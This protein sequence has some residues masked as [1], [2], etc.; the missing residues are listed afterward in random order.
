MM[1]SWALNITHFH[2]NHMQIQKHLQSI[3]QSLKNLSK[4]RLEVYE[5]VA[6]WRQNKLRYPHNYVFRYFTVSVMK[7]FFSEIHLFGVKKHKNRTG[8]MK[9][10]PQS[11]IHLGLFVISGG[12][13]DLDHRRRAV[14]RHLMIFWGVVFLF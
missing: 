1:K 14:W 10:Q 7:L 8:D 4:L 9:L 3:I 13:G 6:K 5:L 11:L 2:R 12:S